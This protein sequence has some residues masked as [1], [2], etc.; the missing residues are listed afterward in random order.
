MN[1]QT[2]V[3]GNTVALVPKVKA[4]KVV[5]ALPPLPYAESALEPV[6]ST[7]TL[8]LHSARRCATASP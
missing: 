3:A 5:F 2:Q 8:R 1:A 7:K 4:A 6:I